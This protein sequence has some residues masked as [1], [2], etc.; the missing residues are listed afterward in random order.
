MLEIRDKILDLF[1]Y[2]KFPDLF[3]QIGIDYHEEN[4]FLNQLID[5]QYR[6]YELDAYLES[7]WEIDDKTLQDRWKNIY[8]SDLLKSLSLKEKASFC[9]EIF[10]Y[11]SHEL[12]LRKGILPTTL[13]FE[14]FYYFKSCD[15]KLLRRLICFHYPALGDE[16]YLSQWRE[17][18]LITELNDDI[19]DLWEDQEVY[20]GNAFNIYLLNEGVEKTKKRF[21]DFIKIVISRSKEKSET[22]QMDTQI[23]NWTLDY[24]NETLD[25]LDE[26]CEKV[27]VL[28]LETSPLNTRLLTVTT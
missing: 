12:N 24:A 1:E 28:D 5:L 25:L 22:N 2:R 17:F 19:E 23:C 13:D 3:N 9:K 6:I 11:Q 27:K 7:N 26:N 4:P 8:E 15:V 18:D 16:E 21:G 10:K 14:F 20:N